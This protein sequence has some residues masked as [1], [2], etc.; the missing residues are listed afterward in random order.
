MRTVISGAVSV[1]SCARS[2]SSS[3]AGSAVSGPE[4][5]AEAVGDGSSTAKDCTSVWSCEASMRPG[6]NGTLTS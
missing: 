3:S 5:V 2:T 1:S 4:V 6:E